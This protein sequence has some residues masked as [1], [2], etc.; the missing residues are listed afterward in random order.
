M[1]LRKIDSSVQ[2]TTCDCYSKAFDL[3]QNTIFD[4]IICDLLENSTLTEDFILR[5]S[6]T[7]PIVIFYR[8]DNLQ[9]VLKIAKLGIKDMIPSDEMAIK[10]LAKTLHT[11]HSEWVKQKKKFL[12]KPVLEDPETKIVVRDMLLT[13]LPIVQKIRSYLTNEVDINLAIKESYDLKVNELIRSNSDLLDSLVKE[14]VL[15]KNKVKNIL[16]CPNCD[17]I[18]LGANYQCQSCGNKLFTKYEETFVHK[19]CGYRGLKHDFTVG[20][21]LYCP[22]CNIRITNIDDCTVEPSYRCLKCQTFFIEP[23][24]NF[25]CNFCDFGPFIHINGRTKT[26]SRYEINPMLEKEF[27]KN[28]FILQ[29]VSDYLTYLDYELSYN[30]RSNTSITTETFFDL[31]A[32]KEDQIIIFV[33]LTS[34]LEYNI[35]LLYQIEMLHSGNALVNPIVISLNEPDQLIF[36]ILSRFKIFSI[37]SDSDKEILAITKKYLSQS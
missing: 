6:K 20:G 36:S 12:L 22:R 8:S 5:H 4:V 21:N 31:V 15:I 16:V 24:T 35:E 27:K 34:Q 7:F 10:Y 26:V 1:I 23:V 18:D 28:F 33:I 30:E 32:R 11:I 17:S 14:R 29:K 19:N 13:E 3:V 37:V 25:R 2:I 9:I